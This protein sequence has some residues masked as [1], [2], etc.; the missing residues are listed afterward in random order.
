MNVEYV[1]RNN[2]TGNDEVVLDPIDYWVEKNLEKGGIEKKLDKIISVLAIVTKD[3]LVKNP[4]DVGSIA[5]VLQCDG[6]DHKID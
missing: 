1:T 3:H 2:F 6:H 4:K 5:Y